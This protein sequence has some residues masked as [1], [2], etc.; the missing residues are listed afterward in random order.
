MEAV[1]AARL[2]IAVLGRADWAGS[3][4]KVAQRALRHL[5]SCRMPSDTGQAAA[6]V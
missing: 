5:G 2:C 1:S 4:L 3:A 6:E